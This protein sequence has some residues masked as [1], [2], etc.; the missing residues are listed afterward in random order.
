MLLS[1]ELQVSPTNEQALTVRHFRLLKQCLRRISLLQIET[2][3]VKLL[4]HAVHPHLFPHLSLSLS[5]FLSL[6]HKHTQTCTHTHRCCERS[7]S[8]MLT[9]Y[10]F[11]FHF[12]TREELCSKHS[13]YGNQFISF[14]QLCMTVCN[15]RF[16]STPGF[17]VH[18]QLPELAEIQIH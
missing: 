10:L 13:P 16:C 1:S 17:L 8:S 14:V 3:P 5:L 4:H 11:V 6:S 18:H 12:E 7:L 9:K 15:P 2:L